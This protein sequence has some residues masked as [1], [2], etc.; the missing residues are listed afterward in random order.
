MTTTVLV[1]GAAGGLG[2]AFALGFAG[3]G[4][5]VAVGDVDLPGAEATAE[6][7]SQRGVRAWAGSLDVTSEQSATSVADAVAT[8]GGGRIDAVVNNAGIFASLQRGP[9]EDIEPDE[10]DRVL[11]VNVKGPWL[12][13]RACSP[14]LP[15]GAAV[16]NVASTTA[17][18]GSP[19][20]LHYVASK[21]A[22]IAMTRGD[23]LGARTARDHR[24]HDRSRLHADRCGDVA[25][26]R[27]R[28]VRRGSEGHSARS[29][30]GRHRRSGPL[31]DVPRQPLRHR[32]DSRRRWRSAVPV[33]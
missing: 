12:V 18:S 2:R 29:R 8:F 27:R 28:G 31:P 15:A 21:G 5:D 13:T 32:P 19:N 33:S 24:Q 30:A 25:A 6:L 10:F 1:T 4:W 16:V 11:H 20:W 26:G 7:V 14:H 17:L 23:G 22:V 3:A 9:F